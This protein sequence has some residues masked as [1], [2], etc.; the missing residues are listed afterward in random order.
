MKPLSSITPMSLLPV[1]GHHLRPLDADLARAADRQVVVLVV[2]DHD[3]GRGNR[4]ADRPAV[5][6][7]VEGVHG[8]HR[9]GLGQAVA[10]EQHGA[11]DFLPA[12]GDG[13]LHRHPAAAR[14]AQRREVEL[15]ETGRVQQ[16]VEQ[17]VDPRDHVVAV[18]AELLDEARE[19]ARVGDQDAQSA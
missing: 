17:R 8:R 13:L 9:A 3:V 11:G 12:V 19:V 6:L 14:D 15:V 5:V 16:R 10:L 7:Q 18:L 4:H 2:A 1:A